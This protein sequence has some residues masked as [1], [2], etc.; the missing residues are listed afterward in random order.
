MGRPQK[1]AI[2]REKVDEQQMREQEVLRAN[3]DLA[4][5]LK[6]MNL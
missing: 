5:Y 4:A 6:N 1:S 3:K 2:I